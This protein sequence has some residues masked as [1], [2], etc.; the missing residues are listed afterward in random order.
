MQKLLN[1]IFFFKKVFND[2][3]QIVFKM[4]EIVG[5]V[6]WLRENIFLVCSWKL[7]TRQPQ[8]IH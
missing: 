2:I 8:A 5:S 1:T 3:Q 4:S 7:S 6:L